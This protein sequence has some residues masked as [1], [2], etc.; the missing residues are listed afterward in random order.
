M[1]RYLSWFRSYAENGV[2]GAAWVRCIASLK[3]LRPACSE[4]M[5]RLATLLTADLPLGG[6]SLGMR[7]LGFN[8]NYSRGIVSS[9]IRIIMYSVGCKGPNQTMQPTAL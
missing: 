9:M 1:F 3:R 5:W 7:T 2:Q 8:K 6:S 4:M